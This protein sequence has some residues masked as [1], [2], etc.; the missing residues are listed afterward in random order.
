MLT[1]VLKRRDELYSAQVAYIDFVRQPDFPPCPFAYGSLGN[2]LSCRFFLMPP[3]VGY[4]AMM[5]CRDALE[6]RGWTDNEE[7]QGACYHA[8]S[9][10]PVRQESGIIVEL[11]ELLAI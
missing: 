4:S 11:I 1:K 2:D 6:P 9:R 5:S 3:D 8:R 7:Y 10:F